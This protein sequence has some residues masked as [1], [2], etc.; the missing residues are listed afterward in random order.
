MDANVLFVQRMLR[1]TYGLVPIIA[2]LD[3]FFNIL[4]DWSVYLPDLVAG[5]VPAE[6]AMMAIG[7]IEILAG[8]LVLSRYQRIGA[9]VVS[10]WLVLIAVNLMA[11]GAWDIAVRD[12]AMAVGAFSLGKLSA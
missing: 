8:A 10:A 2:G 1:W 4:V 6:P 3:K 12:L 11:V 9:Y 7:V 5:L